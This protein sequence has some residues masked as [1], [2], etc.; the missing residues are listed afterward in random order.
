MIITSINNAPT[1]EMAD[2][3]THLRKGVNKITVLV[4]EASRTLSVRIP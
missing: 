1:R 2:V 3:S 4:G